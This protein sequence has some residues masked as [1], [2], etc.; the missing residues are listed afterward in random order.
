MKWKMIKLF[1]EAANAGERQLE[2][3][4]LLAEAAIDGERQLTFQEQMGGSVTSREPGRFE[5]NLNPYADR[6]S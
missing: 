5:F 6:I 4:E 3:D 2:D 1:A